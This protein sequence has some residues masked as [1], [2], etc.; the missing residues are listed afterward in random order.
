MKIT[1]TRLTA[2]Q[3]DRSL[4]EEIHHARM[5]NIPV[6]AISSAVMFTLMVRKRL[7]GTDAKLS[8]E[9]NTVV[10]QLMKDAKEARAIEELNQQAQQKQQEARLIVPGDPRFRN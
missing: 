9:L 3:F 7:Y 6:N 1:K 5:M 8:G 10:G 4:A 2:N